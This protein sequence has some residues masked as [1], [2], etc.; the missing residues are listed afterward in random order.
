MIATNL[1]T[2]YLHNPTGIDIAQPWL[3][4]NCEGGITQTAYQ[5]ICRDENGKT[6]WDSGKTA[7][8]T[9]RAAYD[10]E[11]LKSRSLVAWQ[12]RLWDEQDQAGAWSEIATFELGLLDPTDW[13]AKWITGNYRVNHKRRY[14]VDCF[15]KRFLVSDIKKARLYITA[16]GL[17]EARLGGEKVGN[18]CM[19]PGHTD[20]R[21]RIQYQTYDVTELLKDGENELT[22]QLADGWYRGSCG[23]WGLKSQYGTETKL[24]A[25]LEI[26]RGDGT[27]QT[28]ATDGS[29]D[30]SND[31]PIRF[32][33]NKDGETVDAS[34]VPSYDRKA[35]ETTHNVIPTASNNVPVTEHE[36]LI[37]TE[38][39]APNGKQLFDFG[40]NIAGWLELRVNAKQGQ[41][42]RIRCGEL[43]DE[44]GNLTLK[45]IQ[46]VRRDFATPLQ[47]IDYT[48]ADGEN[49]FKMTF[50]VFGFRYAEVESEVRI[51]PERITAI[52]VYSDMARIGFFDSSNEL[53][54]RFVEATLW[55]MKGNSLDVPTDCPTRERHGWAGDAQIFFETAG[56]LMDYAP[57]ARKYVQDLYDW[58]KKDGKL[59]QIAP[60]GGVDFYMSVMNGSVG[61]SDAGVLIPYRFWKHY[62]DDSLIRKHYDGMARYARFM[63]GRCGKFTPLRHHLPLTGKAKKYVVNYGQSYGEW[64]EPAEVFPNDWKNTVLPH[65][66]EST[67]YTSFIMGYMAEIAD[68]LGKAEDKSL[69]EEYRD[70]CKEAYRRLITLAGH[71][72]DTDRQAKLV[73]PL[74][75][76]LLD[77]KQTDFA[78]KRLVK[79]MEHYG[80][81]L[82]TGFL[83]TP[84]ILD[85]LAS[86]DIEYAYR[87][88][89]NEEMPGWLFMPKNGATT[90]WESWEGTKAQGGIASLNHY[91]KGAVCAWLFKS[92]CGIQVDGENR[93][94][95]APRP[96]GHF[97][98]AR[99]YFRSVFGVVESSWEKNGGSYT[100]TVRI[101]CN[102][103]AE[104]VLP[105]GKHTVVSAGTHQFTWPVPDFAG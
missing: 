5:V 8:N 87:L 16:C 94:I 24:R 95:I 29:W 74:Y 41:H 25:Q 103:T 47:T 44:T 92:M 6:L 76:H 1:K 18:F 104:L 2:E 30:W 52:A 73:R 105:C 14:P 23:A 45:N 61:W 32:A 51:T 68:Y 98:Y 90:I 71:E 97:T 93:F 75:M 11:K 50:S 91:S 15:R 54:N 36:R 56:Y 89:E 102:T 7:G 3:Q 83:S 85:V 19:A 13:Q 17:Y 4:W 12:M 86:L 63:I 57:F 38:T 33:D 82:G 59:P 65:P 70:G 72:L 69:F 81:R 35:K 37:P 9:M 10:G 20:Y 40:Q 39:L 31:G 78:E 27:M 26:T 77:K 22:V 28:V 64:A 79:A 46:C 21:K 58:Q 67:A 53:L 42:I 99:A 62:G 60:Y 49:R 80:W 84:F 55:S 66:E 100:L 48:C 34:C 88:L 101:P 96:G 43:L